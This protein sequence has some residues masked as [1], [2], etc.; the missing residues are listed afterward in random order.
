MDLYRYPE[1]AD[2][3]VKWCGHIHT[4]AVLPD[5]II[6]DDF[7]AFVGQSKVRYHVIVPYPSLI[8]SDQLV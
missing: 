7:D 2:E 1:Q 3:V 8:K 5:V 6:I 4:L